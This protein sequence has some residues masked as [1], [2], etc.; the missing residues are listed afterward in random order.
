MPCCR[1]PSDALLSLAVLGLVCS[2]LAFVLYVRLIAVAGAGRGSLITYFNPIVALALGIPLLGESVT[3][4]GL[5]GLVLILIGSWLAT[6]Q[7]PRH[8][9]QAS[10]ARSP[11]A[12]GIVADFGAS[13]STTLLSLRGGGPVVR[14]VRRR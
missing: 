3:P 1:S 6:R 5:G 13:T 14:G 11:R 8:A 2:A 4:A 10:T 7:P 12:P 9:G